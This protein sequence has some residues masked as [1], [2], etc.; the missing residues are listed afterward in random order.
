MNQMKYKGYTAIIAYDEDDECL[1]GHVIGITDHIAFDGESVSELRKNY[2]NV[3]ECYL[4]AC[5]ERGKAPE[6]PK[7]GKL[8]LR[9]PSELHAVVAQHSEVTGKS[10]NQM[11]VDA[12]TATYLAGTS[13]KAVRLSRKRNGKR[14]ATRAK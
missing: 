13:R 12:L 2:I 10:V 4:K 3:L 5:E 7:S 14:M 9:L 8:S 11:V 6:Q 1:V